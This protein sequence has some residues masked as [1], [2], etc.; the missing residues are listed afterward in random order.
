[1]RYIYESAHLHSC[2]VLGLAGQSSIWPG[3]V[4]H[5][6]LSFFCRHKRHL[7]SVCA[8]GH[9]LQMWPAF[10][11][12]ASC[13]A[14]GIQKSTHIHDNHILV[15]MTCFQKWVILQQSPRPFDTLTTLCTSCLSQHHVAATTLLQLMTLASADYRLPQQDTL[16]AI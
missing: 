7:P 5:V 4:L 11:N 1:M 13:C 14:S 3:S 12:I 15:G 8:M 9:R 6:T 10:H 2:L 16:P